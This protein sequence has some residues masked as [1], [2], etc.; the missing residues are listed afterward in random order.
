V[1]VC[2]T[3]PLPVLAN[4]GSTPLHVAARTGFDEA[5]QVL[6]EKSRVYSTRRDVHGRTAL[7]YAVMLGN[8]KA[9]SLLLNVMTAESIDIDSKDSGGATALHWAT[10]QGHSTAVK[11]LLSK[12]GWRTCFVAGTLCVFMFHFFYVASSRTVLTWPR[13]LLSSDQCV[14]CDSTLTHSH[15]HSHYTHALTRTCSHTL[16][17]THSH[18][19][20]H[21]LTLSPSVTHSCFN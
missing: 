17:C 18:A 5:L 19:H 6:L 20:T 11:V 2:V 21:T 1:C 7:H 4:D 12:V 8:P 3:L 10:A 14:P 9:V 13:A 16:T 15:S